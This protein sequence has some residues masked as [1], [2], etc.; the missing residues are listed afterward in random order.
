MIRKGQ[1]EMQ[2]LVIDGQS[3][4]IGCRIIAELKPSLT[5][6]CKIVCVG[7]NVLA[8]NAMLKA[9]ADMGATG[10]NAIIWNATRADMILGPIGI[11]LANAMLGEISPA[12]AVAVSGTDADK[13]LIPSSK[14]TTIIAGTE[15]CTMEFYIKKA[16]GLA[17]HKINESK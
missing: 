14:C 9:G 6:E 7:T 3:G 12:M 10:E 5:T 4:G 13:I 1:K 17:I 11:I 8:T 2:I 15:S 16:V